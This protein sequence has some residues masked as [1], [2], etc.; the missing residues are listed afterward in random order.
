L[1]GGLV[2]C[3]FKIPNYKR[4]PAPPIAGIFMPSWSIQR[5]LAVYMADDPGYREALG[6]L[7]GVV[8]VGLLFG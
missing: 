1:T 5:V 4:L 6:A 2:S 7:V 3:N 8:V